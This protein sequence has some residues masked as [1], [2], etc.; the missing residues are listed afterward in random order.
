MVSSQ[1][2]Q[3][4]YPVQKNKFKDDRG[5]YKWLRIRKNNVKEGKDNEP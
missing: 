5:G 2:I 1:I 3:K 4:F